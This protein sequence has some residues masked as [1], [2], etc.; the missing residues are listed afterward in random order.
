MRRTGAAIKKFGKGCLAL[1]M[2][3]VLP[4]MA[5]AD[6][7]AA[8]LSTAPATASTPATATPVAASATPAAT[9]PTAAASADK[10]A[11]V[12][13]PKP[14]L[15]A[16]SIVIQAVPAAVGKLP[17]SPSSLAS[18]KPA[19]TPVLNSPPQPPAAA[20]AGGIDAAHILQASLPASLQPSLPEET[21]FPHYPSLKAAVEF[22]TRVFAGWSE[23]QSVLHSMDD[24]SKVYAVLDFRDQ[25]AVLDPVS[26]ASLRFREEMQTREATRQLL[27]QVDALQ[28]TPQSMSIEQHRIYNM[29]AGSD[30]PGRFKNA[31]ETLRFQRGLRERTQH[32]LAVSGRYMP[33][34]EQIFASYDLPKLL[35]RLP[36]MESS[37]NLDAYSKAGAAG[38]WQ[39]IPS[40]ARIYMR[41]DNVVD[42]RRDPWF[43]TDAAAR[44]L[45]DDYDALRDW[46]LALTAYNYG[47][48]GLARALADVNGTSLLDIIARY[49][50]RRFGFASR[51]YYAEFLAA[52]DVERN[53]R[54]H[55]GEMTR[56]APVPFELVETRDY[57]RYDTLRRLCGLDPQTFKTLNPAFRDEVITG[58]LYVPPA[59]PI[60]VPVGGAERFRL[61]Y[62]ALGAD[63]R[64]DRQR[65]LFLTYRVQ[66]GDSAAKIAQRYGVSVATLLGSNGLR[67]AG[68]VRAG[69]T[70]RIP[71]DGS[72][73]TLVAAADEPKGVSHAV[74]V[75]ERVATHAARAPK[76]HRVETGQTLGGIA[77]RYQTTVQLIRK[78]NGLRGDD[79]RVGT[80]LKIPS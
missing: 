59:H 13:Q 17:P 9:T 33:Q 1:L 5:V 16:P 14:R 60:R 77:K 51:N 10:P 49:Q 68:K 15:S 45:K 27:L 30:D 42:D 26:L 25:A 4:A 39:F 66:R 71:S 43:S 64:F 40:S 54:L 11:A 29:F 18:T 62:A 61:A 32:A 22:W 74:K 52:A 31:I 56:D 69:Q 34:M 41:L 79:L 75:S 3:S 55:F 6:D 7:H 37:F 78:F 73:P 67:K 19:T 44:H 35:T 12:D 70:L 48:G 58:K 2:L 53:W 20:A 76:T 23:N 38:V 65:L 28:A 46:P 47:R 63:E 80:L 8:P 57:I 24:L 21:L 50:N 72:G 36:L